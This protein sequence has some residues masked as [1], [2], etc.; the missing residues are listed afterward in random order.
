M[1]VH[2]S[3]FVDNR[4]G[5]EGGAVA[6]NGNTFGDGACFVDTTFSANVADYAGGAVSSNG[7]GAMDFGYE[8]CT[9]DSN[10]AAFGGGAVAYQQWGLDTSVTVDTTFTG[11]SAGDHG[12]AVDLSGG[13]GVLDA[14]FYATTFDGN[15]ALLAGAIQ[16]GGVG[17]ERVLLVDSAVVSSTARYGGGIFIDAS[18]T[19]EARNVDFGSGATDNRPEDIYGTP[20]RGAGET[21]TC[22][23]GVCR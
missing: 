5:Y 17:T 19:V 3:T 2:D 14:S 4:T 11:N 18:S 21:F 9:F 7:W 10:Y 1:G 6:V 23:G 12:G 20:P 22:A 13:W 8:G 15:T 16:A